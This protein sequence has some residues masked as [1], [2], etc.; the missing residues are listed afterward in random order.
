MSSMSLLV[1]CGSEAYEMISMI[2]VNVSVDMG[3][4]RV[5]GLDWIAFFAL[6]SEQTKGS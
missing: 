2:S 4:W 3:I 6:M 5:N 1:L